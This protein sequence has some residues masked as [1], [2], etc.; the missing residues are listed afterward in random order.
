MAFTL[1]APSSNQ[2]L[3]TGGSARAWNLTHSLANDYETNV[4][5]LAC[6]TK[7]IR[8]KFSIQNNVSQDTTCLVIGNFVD[9]I[10]YVLT[11]DSISFADLSYKI[12]NISDTKLILV[13]TKYTTIYNEAQQPTDTVL[14][15]Y[16][17]L[18]D[19]E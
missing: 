15:T 18:F 10:P 6:Q 1:Q 8:L 3:L 13:K 5:S 14:V 4:K 19:V 2:L 17:L 12:Q 11:N 16:K 9:P 7:K